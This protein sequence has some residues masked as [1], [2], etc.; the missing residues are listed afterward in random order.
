M[1]N[2]QIAAKA[3]RQL[4]DPLVIMTG[5]LPTWLQEISCSCPFLFPF[6]TRHLL[7]YAISFDRDRALQRLIDTTPDLN[8]ADTSE[9]VTPRLDRRKRAISREDILKQAEVIIQVF[10]VKA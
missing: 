5:N 10:Y 9:R 3:S 7:F 2:F 4:Q 6:E 8:S 1:N